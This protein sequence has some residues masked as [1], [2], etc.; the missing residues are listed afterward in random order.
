MK[1]KNFSTIAYQILDGLTN[2]LVSL[3]TAPLAL[4]LFGTLLG[5]KVAPFQLVPML[6]LLLFLFFLNLQD[7]LFQRS[8]Q[9]NPRLVLITVIA[10]NVLLLLP[11][12][13]FWF[14]LGERISILLAL[15]VA[16]NH[17]VLKRF[18]TFDNYYPFF[19]LT[20]TIFKVGVISFVSYFIQVK[21]VPVSIL[22]LFIPLAVLYLGIQDQHYRK[23]EENIVSPLTGED[24]PL[25][26][27]LSIL[28][29]LAIPLSYVL[30][31]L[32]VRNHYHLIPLILIL[33]TILFYIIYR[34]TIVRNYSQSRAASFLTVYYLCFVFLSGIFYI[35]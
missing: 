13:Y 25:Q 22:I 29:N 32:L 3:L 11:I 15:V 14:N 30:F 2:P 16:A 34:A 19:L 21:S 12:I 17:L 8:K 5:I 28:L 35:S 7:L 20:Q 18:H 10:S 24:A 9:L 26:K 4:L 31:I 27:I 6:M 33:I 1:T 23:K